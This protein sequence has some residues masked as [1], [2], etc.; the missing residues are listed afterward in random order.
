MSR[1]EPAEALSRSIVDEIDDLL[2]L[3]VRDREEIAALG[4]EE[5]N[6]PVHVLVCASLPW[7]VRLREVNRRSGGLLK[8]SETGE[9]RTVVKGDAA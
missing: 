6:D 9:L 7:G 1:G 3:L 8:L 2:Q 5:T 4:E